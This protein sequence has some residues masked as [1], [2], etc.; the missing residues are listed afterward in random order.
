MLYNGFRTT[1]SVWWVTGEW[2]RWHLTLSPGRCQQPLIVTPALVNQEN[3]HLFVKYLGWEIPPP[4][5]RF[6]RLP[7][8]LA[9][10]PQQFATSHFCT[11]LATS[12][13]G[14][15]NDC[16]GHLNTKS[17]TI[18]MISSSGCFVLLTIIFFYFFRQGIHRRTNSSKNTSMQN[19]CKKVWAA[20]GP[21]HN[22]SR[23]RRW[24]IL[25][26]P[27]PSIWLEPRPTSFT[28]PR[29][30]QGTQRTSIHGWSSTPRDTA[31]SWKRN[32]LGGSGE[33]TIWGN[34]DTVSELLKLSTSNKVLL[35]VLSCW[36]V[37]PLATD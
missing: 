9:P 26:W 21:I 32:Y 29:L 6:R 16:N 37:Y 14:V 25:Q 2:P 17:R 27:R 12:L 5:I 19:Q 8:I 13:L 10:A 33:A 15:C 20:R 4:A 31:H 36:L 28:I 35:K 22:G 30:L 7:R 11:D 34:E 3:Q 23:G 24:Q 1:R 18:E